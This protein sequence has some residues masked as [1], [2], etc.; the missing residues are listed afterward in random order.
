M[1]PHPHPGD[2]H[3]EQPK[4]SGPSNMLQQATDTQRRAVLWGLGGR[5]YWRIVLKES[6]STGQTLGILKLINSEGGMR[7]ISG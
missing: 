7:R 6:L 1:P 2:S 4:P 3:P 5:S